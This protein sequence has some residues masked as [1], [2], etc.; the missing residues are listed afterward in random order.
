VRL[1][2]WC[3][4]VTFCVFKYVSMLFPLADKYE[5]KMAYMGHCCAVCGIRDVELEYKEIFF[6]PCDNGCATTVSTAAGLP[7]NSKKHLQ[8]LPDWLR[9]SSLITSSP[10]HLSPQPSALSPQ[11]SA[12]GRT[13]V[14]ASQ[15]DGADRQYL[16]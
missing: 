15:I 11:P 8:A 13:E 1:G 10:H 2:V 9:V 5:E 7:A 4:R 3:A 12:L 16:L 14:P 6:G